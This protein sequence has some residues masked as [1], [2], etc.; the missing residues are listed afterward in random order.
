[1]GIPTAIPGA[2]VPDPGARRSQWMR[3]AQ[4]VQSTTSTWVP[5]KRMALPLSNGELA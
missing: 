5:D 2:L 1:M 4:F 3:A